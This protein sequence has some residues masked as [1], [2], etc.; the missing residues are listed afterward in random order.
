MFDS[1]NW[2]LKWNGMTPFIYFRKKIYT[3]KLI[4]NENW[5]F[6]YVL[7]LHI[8]LSKQYSKKASGMGTYAHIFYKCLDFE[9]FCVLYLMLKIII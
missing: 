2:C 5:I 4:E 7:R 3:K 1:S 6:L 8:F 9:F